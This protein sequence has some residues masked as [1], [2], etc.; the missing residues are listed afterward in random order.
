MINS[1]K[2][3]GILRKIRLKFTVKQWPKPR[4]NGNHLSPNYLFIFTLSHSGSTALANIMNTSQK[5]IL[6][7]EDGE[8]QW[9]IPGLCAKNRWH[10]DM[11]VDWMSVKKVWQKRYQQKVGG[12][13]AKVIIEKSP[14][15][16][17]RYKGFLD[18]FSERKI[19][20]FNRNPYANCASKLYRKFD[21]D[22]LAE[23][24]RCGYV[25]DFANQWIV[26]SNQLRK[27]TEEYEVLPL[28][29]EKFC[30]QTEDTIS[31]IKTWVPELDDMHEESSIRVKDYPMQKISNQNM[32]QI[33]KLSD[34][35][36]AS[37]SEVLQ[38]ETSLL[39]YFDYELMNI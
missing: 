9:L 25:R 20:T 24:K 30:N 22:A 33:N 16:L 35:E 2:F 36:I 27:I 21:A 14:P 31:L 13:P 10:K 17:M 32:R 39:A 29:Y 3:R 4:L 11:Y 37:I 38:K 19:I 34:R 5:S 23:E 8:G 28:T 26:Y 7:C 18:T 15:N 6:L 12:G 1:V